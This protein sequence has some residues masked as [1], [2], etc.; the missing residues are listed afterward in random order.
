MG[1]LALARGR[2]PRAVQTSDLALV[3]VT[4]A[5]NAGVMRYERRRGEQLQ[6]S[7]LVADSAHTQ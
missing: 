4:L 5:V 7:F 3:L 1:V 6:S 2:E